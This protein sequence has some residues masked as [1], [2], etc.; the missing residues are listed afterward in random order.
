MHLVEDLIGALGYRGGDDLFLVLEVPVDRRS[1]DA[2]RLTDVV[3]SRGV[4]ATL[5]EEGDGDLL[6]LV[7]A[8]GTALLPRGASL[9]AGS[10]VSSSRHN[11]HPLQ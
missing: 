8:I 6:D 7:A 4:I 9:G 2:R 11:Y 10:A 5:M 1:G 3:H